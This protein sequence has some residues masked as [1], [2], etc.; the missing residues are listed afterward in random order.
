MGFWTSFQVT[1]VVRGRHGDVSHTRCFLLTHRRALPR[2]QHVP[3]EGTSATADAPT[4]TRH[5]PPGSVAYPPAH[6]LCCAFHGLG[7]TCD[8]TR[9]ALQCRTGWF[10]R[11]KTLRALSCHPSLPQPLATPHLFTVSIVCPFPGCHTVDS[12]QHIQK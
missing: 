6:C 2:C 10:R 1:A 7:Q 4:L 3:A 8:D 11:P 5:R 12:I 9:L